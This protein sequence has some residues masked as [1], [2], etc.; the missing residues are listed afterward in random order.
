MK[1]MKKMSFYSENQNNYKKTIFF[2]NMVFFLNKTP[3]SL[4]FLNF[5]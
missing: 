3:K 4:K 2:D 1:I 5:N